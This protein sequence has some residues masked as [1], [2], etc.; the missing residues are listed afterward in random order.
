MEASINEGFLIEIL[1]YELPVIDGV[2]NG[3][4]GAK[5]VSKFLG[6]VIEIQTDLTVLLQSWAQASMRSQVTC[7][8]ENDN[9]PCGQN[10]KDLMPIYVYPQGSTPAISSIRRRDES[11]QLAAETQDLNEEQLYGNIGDTVPLVFSARRTK[12][13]TATAKQLAVCGSRRR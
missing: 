10:A 3:L 11:D 12:T 7:Q 5:Q 9:K 2:P 8:E 1:L 4:G 13:P 6:E